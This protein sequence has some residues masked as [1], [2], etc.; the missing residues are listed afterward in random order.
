MELKLAGYDAL[1]I[2]G[3]AENPVYLWLNDGKIEIR[4][5]ADLW[6]LEVAET[7]NQIRCR[8]RGLVLLLNHYTTFS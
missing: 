3:A 8:R 2:E 6:G 7:Q 4:S 5:A 1:I